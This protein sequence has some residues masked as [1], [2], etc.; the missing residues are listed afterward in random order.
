MHLR[1]HVPRRAVLPHRPR[2]PHHSELIPRQWVETM[3]RVGVLLNEGRRPEPA[4]RESLR[5]VVEE[6]VVPFATQSNTEAFREELQSKEVSQR[7]RT[8]TGCGRS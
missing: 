8:C 7:R 3:V 5:M 2:Q 4:L 6:F 1:A